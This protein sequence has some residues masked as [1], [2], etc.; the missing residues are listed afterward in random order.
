MMVMANSHLVKRQIT[1][2]YNMDPARIK[3]IYNPVDM[4]RFS[5]HVRKKLREPTRKMYGFDEKDMVIL[6]ISH[7]YK[8]KGLMNLLRAL[9]RLA[10]K[11]VRLIVV[12]NDDEA[13]YA[14]WAESKGINDKISFIGSQEHIERFYAAADIFVLPTHYDAFANVCLEAMACGLPVVTT[15]NNGASEILRDGEHGFVLR[16]SDPYEL[17]MRINALEDPRERFRMGSNATRKAKSLTMKQ[18]LSTI[19]E[20]YD[21]VLTLRKHTT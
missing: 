5:P 6:F 21:S 20:L 2:Y 10:E 12:G 1:E 18:H 14:S 16:N 11:R 19:L 13:S 3:V 9:Q 4:G 7:D 8:R 17:A 15:Q